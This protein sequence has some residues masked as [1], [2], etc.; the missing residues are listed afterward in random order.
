[1]F[2]GEYYQSIDPKGRIILPVKFRSELFA[3]FDKNLVVV[4]HPDK[5]LMAF[6]LE[7]WIPKEEAL[8]ESQTGS[9]AVRRMKRFFISSASECTVDRQGRIVIPP[10]L[11]LF[12]GLDKDI[13]IAGSIDHFEFWNRER[14]DEYMDQEI[15]DSEE[16]QEMHNRLGF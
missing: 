11:K 16:L 13:V 10:S 3:N 1:M 7:L 12:A 8:Q 5:H 14:Y 9:L 6:P 2:R 15:G 4:K